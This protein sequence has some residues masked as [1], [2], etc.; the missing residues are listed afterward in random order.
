MGQPTSLFSERVAIL[1]AI[2]PDAYS[3]S[4]YTSG[5]V[6]ADLFYKYAAVCLLGDTAASGSPY[7]SVVFSI[8]QG[9]TAGGGGAKL[10]S[11]KTVTLSEIAG[12]TEEN[13][14]CVINLDPD[15]LD[16]DAGFYWIAVRAVVGGTGAGE[17]CD[18][19]AVLLGIDP[20]YSPAS[21]NDSATVN[22]IIA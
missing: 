16:L 19:A 6:K 4:T 15:E 8:Q 1:A 14:Q 11:G 22:E 9:N 13:D 12:G 21:D 20:K 10:V 5:W 3:A 2:D 18:V 7:G 17:A